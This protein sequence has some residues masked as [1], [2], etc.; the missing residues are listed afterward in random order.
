MKAPSPRKIFPLLLAALTVLVTGC[1]HNDYTVQL[2]PQG[3]SID[4]TLVFYQADGTNAT[5]GLSNYQS[6]DTNELALIAAQYPDNSLTNDGDRHIIRGS[7]REHLPADVGGAGTYTNLAT[8]LGNAGFYAERFRG[9][10]DLATAFEKRFNAADQLADLLI[11]WSHAQLGR[12]PGYPQLHQFLDVDFRRDLKNGSAYW[13]QGLFVNSRETNANEEFT[14]RYGQYLFERG[15]FKLGE[16]PP[17]ESSLAENDFAPIFRWNQRLV[18]RKM[19]LPDSE[20]IPPSLAFLAEETTLQESL[21]NYLVHTADYHA[22]LKQWKEV[23]KH[24]SHA[25]QTD[26]MD[27]MQDLGRELLPVDSLFGGTPDH[28]TVKLSLSAPPLHSNG[29]W[30]ESHHQLVWSSD[31]QGRTNLYYLPYSCY[32]NWAMAA[33]DFQ[34]AH[35]GKVAV[36]GDDLAQYCLWRGSQNEQRGSEWDAFL[37]SLKPDNSLLSKLDAFRFTDETNQATNN[38]SKLVS[39]ST[40][41][42]ELLKNALK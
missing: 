31:I 9:D 35:L 14:V 7:F 38:E 15:Y 16:I 11:G 19:G 42:R 27:V 32:A 39:L 5:T 22:R 41:P 1:P 30:D 33:G 36:A 8:S 2:E 12:E 24:D 29:K 3:Q 10:D 40:Y 13:W 20:P 6:F 23:K 21:T 17:L 34:K 26:P 37:A 18:A 25:K 28:L 4:R